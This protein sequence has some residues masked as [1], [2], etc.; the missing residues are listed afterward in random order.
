MDTGLPWALNR[1][2]A[3]NRSPELVKLP[4][5]CC[6]VRGEGQGLTASPSV[7]P[8]LR[9]GRQ[10]GV[11]RLPLALR[12]SGWAG[13]HPLLRISVPQPPRTSPGH[14]AGHGWQAI[15]LWKHNV[16]TS[17]GQGLKKPRA[18]SCRVPAAR[19]KTGDQKAL[20]GRFAIQNIKFQAPKHRRLNDKTQN[21]LFKSGTLDSTRCSGTRT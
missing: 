3:D 6:P 4:A 16:L 15:A 12:P 19:F 8:L 18:P 7:F 10:S 20:Q 17:C 21:P 9:P 13:P 11:H 5:R 1:P 14:G 2:P